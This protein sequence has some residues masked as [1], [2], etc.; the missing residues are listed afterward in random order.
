MTLGGGKS[1]LN[2][3]KK[4][5]GRKENA[6]KLDFIKIENFCSLIHIVEYMKR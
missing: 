5:W 2:K 6:D 4:A 1:F 3:E